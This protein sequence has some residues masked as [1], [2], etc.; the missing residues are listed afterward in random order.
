MTQ[1]REQLTCLTLFALIAAACFV[2][3][4]VYF[5]PT[6]HTLTQV[7]VFTDL[8]RYSHALDKHKLAT[9]KFPLEL[10]EATQHLDGFSA[11]DR[12]GTPFLYLSDGSFYVLISFGKGGQP[13]GDN[14]I[15]RWD[16]EPTVGNPPECEH[17]ETD[18]FVTDRGWSRLCGK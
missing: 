17:P 1:R 16:Q 7:G 5:E 11:E 13:D 14:Y 10:S 4:K 8:V 12:W 6:V 18:Q 3:W 9:G 15:A 2:G